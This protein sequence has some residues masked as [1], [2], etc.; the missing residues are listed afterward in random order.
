[1]S[2]TL[3]STA[4][5]IV[6][7]YAAQSI[8]FNRS[9]VQDAQGRFQ[10]SFTG[11]I[12]YVRT[13]YITDGQGNK[14]AIVQHTFV[15]KMYDPATPQADLSDPATPQADLSDPYTGHIYLDAAALAPYLSETT[16]DPCFAWI[17]DLADTL[18]HADLV[19]RGILAP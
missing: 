2:V 13:D 14:T 19:K 8:Q 6:P 16:A 10:P 17:A 9:M 12:A 1:M 4:G 5:T 18:I 11:N 15:P 7:E 3:P